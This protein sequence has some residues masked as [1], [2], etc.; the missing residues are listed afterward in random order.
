MEVPLF[1]II[2]L[3]TLLFGIAL[4]QGAVAWH[5]WRRGTTGRWRGWRVEAVFALVWVNGGLML[6][7]RD[8]LLARWIGFAGLVVLMLGAW[9]G[10]WRA[11]QGR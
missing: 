4:L 9:Y 2:V 3:S 11:R 1:S 6:L 8:V 10:D 7:L 5:M